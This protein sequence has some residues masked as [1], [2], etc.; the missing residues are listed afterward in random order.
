VAYWRSRGE[1][2][3]PGVIATFASDANQRFKEESLS[4]LP[5]HIERVQ[6]G[7]IVS[8]V[9]NEDAAKVGYEVKLLSR[10]GTLRTA[11]F[12]DSLVVERGG[13]RLHHRESGLK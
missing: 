2:D 12:R 7:W 1:I 13:W 10:D 3:W 6:V 4:A 11:A 5:A 9:G 8:L